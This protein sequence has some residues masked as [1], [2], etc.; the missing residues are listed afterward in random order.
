MADMPSS[1]TGNSFD[2]D[3]R[4]CQQY[5]YRK[6]V[7]G[8]VAKGLELAPPLLVGT[9]IHKYAEV[10]INA[11]MARQPPFNEMV[12]EALHAFHEVMGEPDLENVDMLE[13]EHLAT[14][15]LPLWAAR[16]WARLEDGIEIPLA[17]E[18]QLQI[19]LPYETPYG[20]IRI[21]LRKYTAKID[22]IYQEG[23]TNYV[24]ISDHKGTKALAPAREVQHYLMSD[25]HIGYVACWNANRQEKPAASKIEYSVTRLHMKVTS[26]HTFYDE[27]RN[28]DDNMVSDWYQRMLALRADIT[29]KWEAPRESWISNTVP[30]GPCLGMD[31]R[32]CEFQKLCARPW[33]AAGLLETQYTQEVRL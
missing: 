32:A 5:F 9:A 15:V 21:D 1:G 23:G 29:K 11:W 27:I 7:Q 30:H 19:D 20:P 14:M 17:T 12:E 25:Q 13:R 4:K 10:F 6:H 24:V 2:A 3:F 8:W 33:D 22:Y 28:I 31:S 16:K 18:L 26:E